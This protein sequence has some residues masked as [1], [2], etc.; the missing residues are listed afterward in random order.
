MLLYN[1]IDGCLPV[2][3]KGLFKLKESIHGHDT[4]QTFHVPFINSSTY[5]NRSIRF[6][7]PDLWNK[8]F[9]NAIYTDNVNQVKLDQ[10]KSIYRFKKVMKKYF[11]IKYA[12]EDL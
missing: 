10:V 6:Y 8:T 9:A 5:G 12:Q 1:F 11:L 7:C 3:I 4:R 2:D